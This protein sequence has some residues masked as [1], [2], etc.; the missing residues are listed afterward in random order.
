MQLDAFFVSY[1]VRNIG[2]YFLVQGIEGLRTCLHLTQ[3]SRIKAS[4]I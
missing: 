1:Q 4:Y 2:I 3:F